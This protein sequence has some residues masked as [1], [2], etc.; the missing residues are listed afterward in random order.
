[1]RK[2]LAAAAIGAV[3]IASQ[4]AA[5]DNAAVN[6]DDRVGGPFPAASQV[7]GANELLILLGG[8]L[9]VGLLAY[10]FSHGGEGHPA[11]P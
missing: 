10:G 11:S 2:Y 7:Q 8:A 5:S 9:L 1:M 6:A 3:L 4:A